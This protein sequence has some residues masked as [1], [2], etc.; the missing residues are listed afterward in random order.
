MA[1]RLNI[2][3]INLRIRVQAPEP[4]ESERFLKVCLSPLHTCCGMCTLTPPPHTHTGIVIFLKIFF[5]VYWNNGIKTNS[6]IQLGNIKLLVTINALHISNYTPSRKCHRKHT[7][8]DRRA[9]PG[10]GY[11]CEAT[12][13][14]HI[15]TC[16]TAL[17]VQNVTC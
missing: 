10:E 8:A 16:P 5:K 3:S 17:S 4:T 6:S 14:Y 12:H 11:K 13:W 15:P 7:L 9:S 2:S 1:Y